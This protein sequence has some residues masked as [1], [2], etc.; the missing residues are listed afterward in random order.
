MIRVPE[1]FIHKGAFNDVKVIQHM[2]RLGLLSARKQASQVVPTFPTVPAASAVP[3]HPVIPA[4]PAVMPAIRAESESPD[5]SQQFVRASPQAKGLAFLADAA[6]FPE[7]GVAERYKRLG[8]S[9]RQGQKLKDSLVEQGMIEESIEVT[10]K[11]K[12]RV[13]RLTEKGRLALADGTNM[14]SEAA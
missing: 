11:G 3:A 12:T 6:A 13:I 5:E 1:Y 4:T 7:S 9:V 2:R 10:F 14:Q 8:L